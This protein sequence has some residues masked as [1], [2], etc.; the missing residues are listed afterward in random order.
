MAYLRWRK[1]KGG[2]KFATVVWRPDP[3]NPREERYEAT[4]T[5]DPKTADAQL[6]YWQRKEDA[7][8]GRAAST[9]AAH[10]EDD[11]LAALDLFLDEKRVGV[12]SAATIGT[13]EIK[14]RPFFTA[15]ADK[16]LRAWHRSDFVSYL[17]TK[18]W[19]P[20]TKHKLRT[21]LREFIRWAE[22][23]GIT[24]TDI[25]AGVRL[26]SIR[27][28]AVDV[29]TGEQLAELMDEA[30]KVRGKPTKAG[31]PLRLPIA[32]AFLAGMD[33]SDFL[34][35]KW[36]EV[37]L[38]GRTITRQRKKTGARVEIPLSGLLLQLLEGLPHRKGQVCRGL[39]SDTRALNRLF[40]RL[41]ERAGIPPA[42]PGQNGFRRL[43]HTQATLMAAAGADVATIGKALGHEEGSRMALRYVERDRG[44]HAD[45]IKAVERAMGLDDAVDRAPD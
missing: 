18:E 44:R 23:S 36:S 7:A 29:L 1:R 6:R 34:S 42:P 4:G 9:S 37:D 17:K 35:L 22:G 20:A 40:R 16:P 32:L 30:G 2:R 38:A 15:L 39:P 12:G 26:P 45:A 21:Q 43:R 8:R 11:P 5:S 25:T 27:I 13:Y 14:L 3:D 31:H 41:C 24:C 33:P 10:T 19:Q 28:H